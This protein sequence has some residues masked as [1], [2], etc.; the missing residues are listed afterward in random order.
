MERGGGQA[1]RVQLLKTR[2]SWTS[3]HLLILTNGENVHRG[4]QALG[5]LL[6]NLM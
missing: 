3:V 5:L 2:F 6:T 1:D 4:V